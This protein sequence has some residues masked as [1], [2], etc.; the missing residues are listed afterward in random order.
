VQTWARIAAPVAFLVAVIVVVSL[1][2][3]SGMVGGSEEKPAKP[4]AKPSKTSTKSARPTSSAKP[5]T[6]AS[7]GAT[8]IYTVKPG[9]TLSGIAEKFGVGV[10]DVEELNPNKD[11]TTLQPGEKLKIPP[12]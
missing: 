7:P 1:A 4:A 3:Q 5:T 8:R 2:F 12:K 11:L 9:D 6:S 10:T